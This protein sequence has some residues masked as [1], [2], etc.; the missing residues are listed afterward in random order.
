MN[1]MLVVIVLL[2]QHLLLRRKEKYLISTRIRQQI[3]ER[4][5][6]DEVLLPPHHQIITATKFLQLQETIAK[7]FRK[8]N[9][10]RNSTTATGR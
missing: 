6:G 10:F 2:H 9:N 5:L 1:Q 8:P 4:E 3:L 7:Y